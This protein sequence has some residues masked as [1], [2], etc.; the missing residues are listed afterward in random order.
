MQQLIITDNQLRQNP[1]SDKTFKQLFVEVIPGYEEALKE[2][3]GEREAEKKKI[4]IKT[5]IQQQKT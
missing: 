3:E 2:L 1:V 4:T 5:T